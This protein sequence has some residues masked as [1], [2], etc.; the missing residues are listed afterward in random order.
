MHPAQCHI[1]IKVRDREKGNSLK[2]GK[3]KKLGEILENKAWLTPWDPRDIQSVQNQ[4][5]Y[6]LSWK[7]INKGKREGGGTYRLSVAT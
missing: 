7:N 5:M 3:E 6:I 4:T 1:C 2:R